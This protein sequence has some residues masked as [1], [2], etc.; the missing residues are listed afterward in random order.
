MISNVIH[1]ASQEGSILPNLNSLPLESSHAT[2][3]SAL[4]AIHSIITNTLL[5]HPVANA[6]QALART[7]AMHTPLKDSPMQ[8]MG[9]SFLTYEPLS[10]TIT[11]SKDLQH[12]RELWRVHRQ[13]REW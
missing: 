5:S 8:E 11:L 2:R 6:P 3:P 9:A 13:M 7:T 1:L 12:P 10:H 4:F